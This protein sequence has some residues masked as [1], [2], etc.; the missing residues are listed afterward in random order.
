MQVFVSYRR[1][2]VPDATDRLTEDLRERFGH[3]NV[4]IDIDSIEIGADFVEVIADWVARADVFLAVIG[5]NWIDAKRPD[6]QRRIDDPADYVRIEIEAALRQNQRA[7]PVLIHGAVAPAPSQL[8]VSVAP[9]MRRNAVELTRRYWDEDIRGLIAALERVPPRG[10]VTSPGGVPGGEQ[11]PASDPIS[12]EVHRAE[13]DPTLPVVASAEQ[14][15]PAPAAPATAPAVP[16]TPGGVSEPP[17][18][19]GS[20]TPSDR[21]NRN[22]LKLGA[23]VA[24]AAGVIAIVVVAASGGGGKGPSTVGGGGG[25]A[26]N[27]AR[28]AT[29]ATTPRTPSAKTVVDDFFSAYNR[30]DNG[31]AAQLWSPAVNKTAIY[32]PGFPAN[33][34]R[35]HLDSLDAVKSSVLSHGCQRADYSP[36]VSGDVVTATYWSVGQRP[37][38]V[39]CTAGNQRWKDVFTVTDGHITSDISSRIS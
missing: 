15:G 21:P 1:D 14:A 11:T 16:P 38:Q 31:A 36:I 39:K 17:S 37:G 7:V 29:T 25:T 13:S 34:P 18:R 30:G 10:Q 24:V 5:R 23:V 19:S 35:Q 8:P 6:G 22:L 20:H 4:F 26:S 27:A 9:L 12:I 32:R 33:A 28:T 3:E 2:D